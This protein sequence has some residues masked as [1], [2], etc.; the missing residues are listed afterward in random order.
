[1]ALFPGCV[2]H[3]DHSGHGTLSN[4][5]RLIHVVIFDLRSAIYARPHYQTSF[6]N[7]KSH[8]AIFA[9]ILTLSLAGRAAALRRPRPRSSGRKGILGNPGFPRPRAAGRGADGATRR[10]YPERCQDALQ[11]SVLSTLTP[12]T[13]GVSGY[14]VR[15]AGTTAG[16]VLH[17]FSIN[18]GL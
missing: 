5:L 10:P 8:I 2:R 11:F 9:C 6:V 3:L 4:L 14:K 7:G 16:P 15:L 12:N 13:G 17:A 18:Y 1:M